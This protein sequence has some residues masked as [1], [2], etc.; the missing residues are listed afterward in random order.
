MI[1]L[2]K[3]LKLILALSV[4]VGV[5]EFGHFIFAR[6]FGVRVDKFYLFFDIGG[7]RLFST[8]KSRWFRRLV[9]AA[10][11]WETDYGI[12][13][14]PLGGYCK[15]AGMIDES[16]DKSIVGTE[17]QLWELR[18]KKPWQRL[19][20]MAGGVLFNFLLAILL[21]VHVLAV[22][23]DDH[24]DNSCTTLLAEEGMVAYD[25]G[26]RSGDRILSLDGKSIRWFD[27]IQA[28]IARHDIS[29]V[30]VLRG[31]DTLDIY[32]DSGRTGELLRGRVFMPDFPFIIDLPPEGEE[33]P[34]RALLQPGDQIV[35]LDGAPVR[36]FH[37][38]KAYLSAHPD[39]LV[40][41]DLLRGG[42][43]LRETLRVDA[44][45]RIGVMVSDLISP[46]SLPGYTHIDY[47]YW[48][49]YPAGLQ[50]AWN[51]VSGYVLDLKLIFTPRTKAY[52]SVGSVGT[53]AT[54]MPVGWDWEYY[55]TILALLS[56]MLGVMNL[57]PIPA[58]DGG[59]IVFVLYEMISGRK[60]S[61]RFM[62]IAQMIGMTLLILL[63]I[64]AFGNDFIHLTR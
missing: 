43:A 37:E 61:D 12:G 6:I 42:V 58:L 2:I 44:S 60:P 48:A 15:I 45:G 51:T 52:Q 16:M 17:P 5:H 20:V 46:E 4:I 1:I 39:T 27:D 7:R 63:M 23:G 26:F 18:S 59:H 49:S 29:R 32:M 34:N 28:Y 3:I 35:A 31:G 54:L 14:L 57:L 30:S 13:W 33:S 24:L 22:W 38:G 62:M 50:K 11:H 25:M 55:L 56:V 9:P 40:V 19:F 8:K 64:I 10:E 53:M 41:A 36:F 47:S 21:F